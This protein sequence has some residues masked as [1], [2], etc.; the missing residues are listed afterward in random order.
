V[1]AALKWEDFL[2]VEIV[3]SKFYREKAKK[4]HEKVAF[5][6]KKQ[7]YM[8]LSP[9][10]HIRSRSCSPSS[11]SVC[12]SYRSCRPTGPS[13]LIGRFGWVIASEG[14]HAHVF[15]RGILPVRQLTTNLA[16]R[17]NFE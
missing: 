7:A 5:F 12:H 8:F 11:T 4:T 14:E 10:T 13:F 15:S 9:Q 2:L 3:F 6:P 1:V 16:E 17:R